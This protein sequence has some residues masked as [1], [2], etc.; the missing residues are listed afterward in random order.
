MDFIHHR[1]HYVPFSIPTYGDGPPQHN[2]VPRDHGHHCD[3]SSASPDLASPTTN[4]PCFSDAPRSPRGNDLYHAPHHCGCRQHYSRLTTSVPQ[5]HPPDLLCHPQP[6]RCC[7]CS[8]KTTVMAPLPAAS[9]TNVTRDIQLATPVPCLGRDFYHDHF[10]CRQ[11][12]SRLTP[13]VP[14]NTRN[15]TMS[16]PP[17]IASTSTFCTLLLLHL[18]SRQHGTPILC[19]H[20]EPD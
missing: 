20:H 18:H 4:S 10:D 7:C 9:I 8:S 1:H 11:H 2:P 17:Y 13:S 6:A 5:F 3:G 12:S 15:T 19:Q 16:H 14:P